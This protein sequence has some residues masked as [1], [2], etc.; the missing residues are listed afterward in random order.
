VIAIYN[1][2]EAVYGEEVRR[3]YIL[4]VEVTFEEL[5]NSVDSVKDAHYF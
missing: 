2:A 1:P 4:G 5:G 3:I